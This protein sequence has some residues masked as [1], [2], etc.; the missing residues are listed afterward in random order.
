GALLIGLIYLLGLNFIFY[1]F[2]VLILG[3]G[4]GSV[5]T[6][7]P[8]LISLISQDRKSTNMGYLSMFR[9]IGL[10]VSNI[11]VGLIFMASQSDAYFYAFLSAMI[12][13]LIVFRVSDLKSQD[14]KPQGLNDNYNYCCI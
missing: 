10:F 4:M 7:E 13:S 3:I 8:T 12:A 11:V 5:E 6:Y 9:S 1:Y 2:S 14:L